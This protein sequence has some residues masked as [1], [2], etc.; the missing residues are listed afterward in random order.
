MVSRINMLNFYKN[1]IKKGM[2][3]QRCKV[4][5]RHRK[6]VEARERNEGINRID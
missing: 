3:R 2:K 6:T 5:S 1:P 4:I